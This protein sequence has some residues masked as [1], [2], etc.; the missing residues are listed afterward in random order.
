MRTWKLVVIMAV[1]ALAACL[2]CGCASANNSTPESDVDEVA[3]MS[4]Q[5]SDEV[6][7]EYM[8]SMDPFYVLVMGLD[9][10][11]GTVEDGASKSRSD[12]MMLV[13][14]DPNTREI[15]LLSV[16]RDTYAW[17]NDTDNKINEAYYID[18][19]E[20]AID[21]VE[22][23]TGVRA[24]YYMTTTFVGFTDLIDGLGGVDAYVPIDMDFKNIVTGDQEYLTAGDQHLTGGQALVLARVRKA[25]SWDGDTHRQTNSRGMVENIIRMVASNPDMAT[26]YADLL[27]KDCETNL[28]RQ[29]F[30]GY[31]QLFCENADQIN[32]VDGT[33]PY[34]NGMDESI[35][36]WVVYRDEDTSHACAEAVNNHEDPQAIV[37]LPDT[38]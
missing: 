28:D 24:D 16:P 19:P 26:Q 3:Q 15:G 31:V 6:E 1:A 10:G 27:Y 37:P 36:M 11:D 2:F 23:L 38:Y 12:T 29:A 20:A 21:Q 35:D 25:Y 32:F 34:E 33:T 30:D 14:V 13:R 4:D 22:L 7:P 9:T 18:G 17:I 5:V 8:L